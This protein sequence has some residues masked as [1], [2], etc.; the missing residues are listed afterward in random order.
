MTE[1]L[2]KEVKEV[3]ASLPSVNEEKAAKTLL[4]A[5]QEWVKAGRP[6]RQ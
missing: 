6:V 3:I 2:P 5:Y 1:D 4:S